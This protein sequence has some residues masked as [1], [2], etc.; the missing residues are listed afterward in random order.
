VA[1]V[2][3]KKVATAK[4]FNFQFK[5]VTKEQHFEL[6]EEILNDS[7]ATLDVVS[8]MV[9]QYAGLKEAYTEYLKAADRLNFYAQGLFK[10]DDVLKVVEGQNNNERY[11]SFCDESKM[12]VWREV[13]KKVGIERYMTNAVQQ[14]FNRFTQ[15][16][17]AL[18]FTIEN[19]Q[20]LVSMLIQNSG[21]ILEKAVIDLFDLFTSYYHE[22]RLHVEGWKTNDKWKVNQKVILPNFLS[23]SFSEHYSSNYSRWSEYSDIDR[24][25]CY[26]TGKRYED[27]NEPIKEY[28]YNAK[29]QDKSYKMTSLQHAVGCTRWGDSSLQE[30]EFFNFRC[31]KK[32]TLHITFKD[33]FLWQD[34]NMRACSGKNWLPE[35]ERKQWQQQ[36]PFATQLN[37]LAA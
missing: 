20:A 5:N 27:F 8:N 22:N 1:L 6:N 9:L 34:F 21:N 11:N 35:K 37:L 36:K 30:S 13:I 4:R 24:V 28:P 16:Q 25:M 29:R 7:V 26:L 18:D 12:K 3:L 15:T 19:I 10:V 23:S 2:R 32:G 31:Y 33:K 17:G 14:N